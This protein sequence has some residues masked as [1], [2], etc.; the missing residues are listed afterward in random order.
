MSSC[1]HLAVVSISLSAS[2]LAA[3]SSG[4]EGSNDEPESDA[5]I[6][7]VPNGGD[8]NNGI[9]EDGPID[10]GGGLNSGGGPGPAGGPLGDGSACASEQTGAQLQP[11]V[12]AFAFDV[13]GSM[14]KGDFPYHERTLKWDPVV[15]ASKAFFSDPRSAGLSA[16]LTFFPVQ[17]SGKCQGNAY[18]QPVVPLTALPSVL[19]GDAIDA[20]TPATSDDWI[21]GTPTHAVLTGTYQFL[22]QSLADSPGAHHAVVLVTD[23]YPQGCDDDNTIDSAAA[24]VASYAADV[25][26]YVIGV[27]NPATPQEPNPPD[28]V[29]NLNLIAESGGTQ[30][31][32]IIDT[33]NA[34]RTA[35]D[36]AAVVETIR[37]N[38]LSCTMTI[39]P[40]PSGQVLD[41]GLVN[42][43]YA[44]APGSIGLAYSEDCSLDY[45]WRFDDPVNP[46][47][48]HLCDSTCAAVLADEL[49]TLSVEF[50]CTRRTT[51]MGP[52]A[53]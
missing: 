17:G 36:F 18:E 39:P 9:F 26:T 16:S 6:G 53:R 13:S 27:A 34:E 12:L 32:F 51:S 45:A 24:F 33:G 42:V 1:S 48:L 20:Q 31:A 41:T 46:S 30:A 35:A 22:Q 14:G 47:S 43:T 15:A 50:G 49:A 10:N 40:P 52:E 28:V 23:G 25:P 7:D 19:F 8:P 4:E 37:G 5:L 11:V 21:G 2:C 29:S 38:T 44:G 3:C